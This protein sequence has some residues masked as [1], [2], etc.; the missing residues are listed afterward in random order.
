MTQQT[1]KKRYQSRSRRLTRQNGLPYLASQLPPD[2]RCPTHVNAFIYSLSVEVTAGRIES[3]T[4]AGLGYLSQLAIQ[5]LPLLRLES[6]LVDP[7]FQF[8]THVSRPNH[9]QNLENRDAA[10]TATTTA[11][12]QDQPLS[13]REAFHR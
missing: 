6:D 2:F 7:P 4:A 3:R 11:P 9:S 10:T 5:T 1:P 13:S 12:A 8:I